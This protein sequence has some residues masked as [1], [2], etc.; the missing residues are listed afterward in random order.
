MIHDPVTRRAATAWADE[1]GG[2][3]DHLPPPPRRAYDPPPPLGE[4]LRPPST[5]DETLA[6]EWRRTL[7]V[8]AAAIATGTAIAAL[9]DAAGT[10][11]IVADLFRWWLL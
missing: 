6:A 2:L 4:R 3:V 5:E 1:P 7:L 10:A 9:V 8:L 11:A